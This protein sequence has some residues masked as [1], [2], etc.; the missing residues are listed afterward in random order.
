MAFVRVA[1]IHRP[2]SVVDEVVTM[3]L[4]LA[5]GKKVQRKSIAFRFSR[6]LLD[7][8]GWAVDKSTVVGVFEGIGED[9]GFWQIAPDTSG[10]VVATKGRDSKKPNQGAAFML[11]TINLQH[12]V[13]NE[14]GPVSA[15]VVQHIVE[16]NILI[17][18]CP[19]WLR[20]NPQ[21]I[22]DGAVQ[23]TRVAPEPS[24][25]VVHVPSVVRRS[26]HVLEIKRPRGRPRKHQ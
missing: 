13:L 18:E 25:Q 17:I 22:Q 10:Y 15:K 23:Q 2:R 7:K 5:D 12:Y 3:G 1:A 8:L 19:D 6:A 9:I 4:Y 14:P 21:S 24:P 16:G 11:N 20:F 26:A